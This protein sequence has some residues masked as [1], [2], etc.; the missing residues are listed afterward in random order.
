MKRTIAAALAFL[1]P[2]AH[3]EVVSVT[4]SGFAIES[5]AVVTA[6]PAEAYAMLGRVDAWWDGAHSYSGD[7]ANL[8]IEMKPGGC[9]CERVP[10]GD[11]AVEH[12]RVVQLRPGAMLRLQGGL[13]PLQGE[14]VSGTLTWALKPVAGGTE[15]IQ[16]YVVGG[17]IR[18]GAEAW[19]KPVDGVMA[20]QLARL[21]RRL[22]ENVPTP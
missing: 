9:F 17:Y 1:A 4:P 6:T 14:G 2:A 11:G 22:G 20:G 19:A 7:A 15:I 16:T 18:G 3:A 10:D 13:G 5:K 12:M 8:R 21:A